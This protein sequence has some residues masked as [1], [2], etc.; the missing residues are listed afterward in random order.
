MWID[1]KGLIL[2]FQDG[3]CRYN[4]R[5]SGATDKGFV[6][7][8]KGSERKLQ[9]AVATKGP[10]S[11]G[12]DASQFSFQFYETGMQFEQG[13]YSP[14]SLPHLKGLWLLSSSQFC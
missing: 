3:M 9:E 8:A 6:D 12:T 5:T 10:I 1:N 2:S 14:S 11:V 7:I 13:V 4:A